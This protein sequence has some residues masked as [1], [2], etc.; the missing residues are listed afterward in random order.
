MHDDVDAGDGDSYEL[1]QHKQDASQEIAET[2]D[3]GTLWLGRGELNNQGFG[4]IIFTEMSEAD[5]NHI[6]K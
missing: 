1:P 3:L 4:K 6:M 2:I 5:N